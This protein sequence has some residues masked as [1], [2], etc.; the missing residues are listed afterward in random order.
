MRPVGYERPREKLL[1][2]GAKALNTSELLQ[3]VIGSGGQ[4][5]SGAKVAASLDVLL[6]QGKPTYEQLLNVPGMGT[7][8]SCQI[9]AV[10]E[11]TARLHDK[12]Y[13]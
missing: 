1:L 12:G 10:Y 9:L 13:G 3:L 7:A 5:I 11:L 6:S 8:K 4:K 2:R